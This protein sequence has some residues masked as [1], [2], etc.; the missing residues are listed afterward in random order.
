MKRRT[1]LR[2]LAASCALAMLPFQTRQEHR[3]GVILRGG[4]KDGLELGG[5]TTGNLAIPVFS[6]NMTCFWVSDE[7]ATGAARINCSILRY[8]A[9]GVFEDDLE[10]FRPA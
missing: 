8:R 3:T 10:V 5:V 9:T 2:S 6:G 1:F 7:R 4:P